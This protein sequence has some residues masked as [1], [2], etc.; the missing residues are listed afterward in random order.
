MTAMVEVWLPYGRTEVS[1]KVPDENFLGVLE[2][3]D[4]PLPEDAG[5]EIEHAL[6]DPVDSKPLSS[7]VSSGEKVAIVTDDATRPVPTHLLLEP[8]ITELTR[9][10]ITPEDITVIIGTGMHRAAGSEEMGRIVGAKLADQLKSMNHD[11]RSNTL[12]RVGTTS[13]GTEVLLNEAFVKA[14]VRVLTGD[15]ELHHYAGYGGGRKSVLPGVSGEQT[16]LQNHALSL[17]EG[18]GPG[19]MKGNPVSEDMTEAAEMAKVDFI[20]NVVLNRRGE[21]V[22]TYS[23]DLHKA[24]LRGTQ[25][26][27]KMCKVTC[28]SKADIAVVSPGGAPR[29]RDL[30]DSLRAIHHTLSIVNDGGAIILIA[31]CPG[32]HGSQQLYDWMGKIDDPRKM[33]REIRKKFAIGG[34]E[35]CFLANALERVKIYLLSSIPDYYVSNVFKMRPSRTANGALQAALRTVGKDSK[36]AIVPY[37]ATTLPMLVEDQ[38]EKGASG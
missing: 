18:A 25:L 4:E 5:P 33:E 30:Y 38:K 14:D 37:G 9:A 8:M 16:I 19:I 6:Q 29:D 23:G 27:D 12:V 36:I 17:C 11:C 32:G 20:T 10:N 28:E 2:P 7:I 22:K 35:A 26:V 21:I 34:N 24:F 13:H 31:E 15:I 1:V 3:R